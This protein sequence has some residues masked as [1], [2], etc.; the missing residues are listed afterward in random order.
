MIEH[1][2]VLIHLDPKGDRMSDADLTFEGWV[3]ANQPIQAVW[4][5]AEKGKPLPLC[6]RPD[7]RRV[8]PGRM[9][10]GFSGTSKARDLSPCGLRL[11]LQIGDETFEVEHPLPPP[12]TRQ[13]YR[14]RILSALHLGWLIIRERM[15]LTSSQRWSFTLRR[16]LLYQRQRSNVFRRSHTDALLMDFAA[17][18]P[19]VV[20]VQIGANDG[21]TGDPI[22][23]LLAREEQRWRG[24]LVEPVGHLFAQLQERYGRN[25]ALRLERAAIGESNGTAI[26]H[27]VQTTNA[28]SLW[29]EQLA[30][31]DREILRRNAR[32]FGMI[33]P[34][35][36]GESVPI[37]DVATLLKRHDITRL[38]LVIIDT[39]GWDWRILRQFDLTRWQPKLILYEHQHLLAEERE[40]A[41]QML[42]RFDYRWAETEEGDTLAWSLR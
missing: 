10:V 38:D 24:V 27:R 30:S 36:I 15:A 33:E 26:I 5:A 17:A 40:Q 16:H 32:Q 31:L 8:L 3:A 6:D 9:A 22:H 20:F 41:H 13:S 39:E 23:H 37:F 25:S 14:E 21:L 34:E 35:I 29:L 11:G 28:D 12:L 42:T 19:E 18:L 7:V 2:Q 1:K 4:L